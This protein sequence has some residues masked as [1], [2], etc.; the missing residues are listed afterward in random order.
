MKTLILAEGVS[1]SAAAAQ[2][3]VEP[4]ATPF[5]AGRDVVAEILPQD[6]TGTP[7]FKI[8]GSDD[9]SVWVDLLTSTSLAPK[10]GNI[11]LR[12]YMRFNVTAAGTAGN[13]SAYC[14]NGA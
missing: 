13:V 11:K 6:V 7:T 9:N 4:L 8:Q 14:E 5:L 1:A 12:P 3:A 10:K 2:A